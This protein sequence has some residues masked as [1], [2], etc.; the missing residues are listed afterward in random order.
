LKTLCKLLA[1]FSLALLCAP[2]SHSQITTLTCQGND[3][4]TLVI[5]AY[6]FTFDANATATRS[7]TV[8]TDASM[9]NPLIVDLYFSPTYAS[10]VFSGNT[11]LI[12]E[13]VTMVDVDSAGAAAGIQS[14]C[15]SQL[16]ASATFTSTFLDIN[17]NAVTP[18]MTKPQTAAEQ[19]QA[20]AAFRARGL[21]LP[22]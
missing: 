1:L 19:A 4:G 18:A 15:G 11:G 8:Y 9:L 20:L 13:Q 5:P 14:P 3:G 10:C 21:A 7:F 12:L 22:K 6:A 17:Q 2:F 16:Y